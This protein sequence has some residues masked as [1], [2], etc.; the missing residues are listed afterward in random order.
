VRGLVAALLLAASCAAHADV[1]VFEEVEWLKSKWIGE[2]VS[3]AEAEKRE[4]STVSLPH[5]WYWDLHPFSTHVWY[6]MRF[7]LDY[8]PGG[9][10]SLYLPKVRVYDAKVYVNKEPIWQFSDLY[11]PGVPAA[12][13]LIPIPPGLLRAGENTIHLYASGR[14]SWFKGMTRVYFGDISRLSQRAD[15]RKLIE[16]HLDHSVAVAYGVIS[17]LSLW[18]WLR[19]GRDPVLFWYGLS[20]VTLLAVTILYYAALW[21]GANVGWWLAL[22]FMRFHGYLVPF[23]ILHLRIAGRR[24][25]WLESAFWIVLVYA[26]LRISGT[27]ALGPSAHSWFGWTLVFSLLPPV[28]AVPLLMTRRLRTRPSVLALVFADFVAFGL[29]IHHIGIRLGIFDFDQPSFLLLAPLF[30]MLAAAVPITERVRAGF[31]ADEQ[32][33]RELERRVAEK[34]REIEASYA[35]LRE[36][37]RAQELAAE[38]RRIMADMHD[39]LGARLVALLSVAQSGKAK[40][41]EIS[42]GIAG[43]LDDLR[44]A[45]DSVQPVEGDVGV[46]LGNVR[47]RMRQVFE[48]AGIRLAWN[49]AALPR[50]SS[51]TPERVLAIQR[52]F[53]EAFSNAIR[54]S[55][56]RSVSVSTHSDANTV[57]IV[58]EDDGRGFDCAA[59]GAGTGLANLQLRAAQ[60]GGTLSV[61]SQPGKGTRVTLSLPLDGAGTA[62]LLPSTGQESGDYP[63][64]GMAGERASA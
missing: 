53:F 60:A 35:K 22:L 51:L 52:V 50:M 58:I 4:W 63:D 62:E 46:V 28:L 41:G 55:G 24:H 29:A 11:R 56:A 26:L 39:G 33:R 59:R 7:H 37:Q 8:V 54:H 14:P 5:L 61:E 2:Q 21:H 42:E 64:Q 3:F 31:R 18:L 1:Q 9:G 34:T 10:Q 47:H 17:L 40:P 20:G 57:Q 30:V 38:R 43:A 48:R 36:T 6:R 13:I 49:V 45:V 15:L 23:F 16:E 19:A 25:L 12:A 44:L 32:N 27:P